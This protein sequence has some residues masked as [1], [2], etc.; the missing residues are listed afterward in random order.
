MM[1]S[2]SQ[3]TYCLELKISLRNNNLVVI[4][5]PENISA[6]PPSHQEQLDQSRTQKA[7]RQEHTEDS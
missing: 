1:T 5:D 4:S 3:R 2:N 6:P 7:E